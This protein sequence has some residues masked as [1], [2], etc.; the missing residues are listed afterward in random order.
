MEFRSTAA[1]AP[2]PAG[3]T[4]RRLITVTGAGVVKSFRRVRDPVMTICSSIDFL[5]PSGATAEAGG[6]SSPT[7]P[8]GAGASVDGVCS[9]CAAAIPA[10]RR[11]IEATW[12]V[13]RLELIGVPSRVTAMDAALLGYRRL[14]LLTRASQMCPRVLTFAH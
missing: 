1:E 9:V 3:T 14:P 5:P 13:V 8:G 12:Y 11:R 6:G 10:E 2:T 7:A 4:R